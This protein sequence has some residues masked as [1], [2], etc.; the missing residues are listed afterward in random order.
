M[1]RWFA[2]LALT[3]AAP[4]GL[5]LAQGAAPPPGPNSSQRAMCEAGA[6]QLF[7]LQVIRCKENRCLSAA[8]TDFQVKKRACA[9][10]R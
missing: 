8:N 1:T 4:I 6:E 2:V 3:A 5:A 9:A 10:L 7:H